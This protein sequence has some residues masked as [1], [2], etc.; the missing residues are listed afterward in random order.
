[1]HHHSPIFT[2]CKDVESL[3]RVNVLL[4]C[5][6]YTTALNI[7][8]R[9]KYARIKPFKSGTHILKCVVAWAFSMMNHA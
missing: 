8:A 4:C 3:I 1:M 6:I 5:G 7:K 9:F 2:A